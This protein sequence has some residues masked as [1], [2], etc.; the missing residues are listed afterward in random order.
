MKLFSAA[1]C[2]YNRAE[3]LPALIA[4]LREQQCEMPFE[5]LIVDNNST[6]NTQQV[7]ASLA[8]QSGVHLR[9]VKETQQGIPFA[10]NR[11][12]QECIDS[13]FMLFMDD[14]EMPKP[15]LLQ[16]A[17]HCLNNDNAECAGGKINVCF[18]K[19][20]RPPWLGN[21]L[22]GFLAEVDYGSAPFWITSPSTPLWTANIAYRMSIFKKYPQ[23][24]FNLHYNRIGKQV[25]GGEDLIMF[26]DML[27]LNIKMRYCPEM[28]V[29]HYVEEW[30]LQR[31]YFLKL[32]FVSGKKT[33]LYE[34]KNYAR[35]LLGVPFFMVLQSMRQLVR[36]LWMIVT[37]H[38]GA[39]RQAMNWTHSLGLIYGYFLTWKNTPK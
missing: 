15:G 7:L 2:S 26:N 23:L 19:G 27:A 38:P 10:R 22:L 24:R 35:T 32:H 4:A 11:A 16:A 17:V 20:Q 36:S 13:E 6:D 21:D 33:G 37:R 1:L 29:E 25:G 8:T 34:A 28:V 39:L 14:D 3:R 12:L 30:R 5:I 18:T 9:Y 31:N